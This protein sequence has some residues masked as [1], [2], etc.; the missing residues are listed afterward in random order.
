MYG[1]AQM[2]AADYRHLNEVCGNSMNYGNESVKCRAAMDAAQKN[3]GGFNVYALYDECYLENDNVYGLYK[4]E[5]FK[6]DENRFNLKYAFDSAQSSERFDDDPYIGNNEYV[7]GGWTVTGIY[8]NQD[9]VKEAAHIPL[10]ITWQWQDGNWDK[11]KSTQTDLTPYYK[12]W[13]KKYRIL[14]YFGDTDAGVP[15]NGGEEWTMNLG[16]PVAESWRA[17]TPTPST[18]GGYVQIYETGTNF[19]YLTIRG[20]GHMVPQ[21]RPFQALS[22]YDI[23][24]KN[25]QYPKYR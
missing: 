9:E 12:E 7:C 6:Y 18:M 2:S 11:Y 3:L 1:H 16:Y 21:Y 13:V 17:W 23:F 19:S 22:M 5:P 8:L 4:H 15:Y 20:A 25:G 10:N 14:I 24:L